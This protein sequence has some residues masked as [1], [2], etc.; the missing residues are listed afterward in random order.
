MKSNKRVKRQMRPGCLF[1]IVIIALGAIILFL[2]PLFNVNKITVEGNGRLSRETILNAS[3]IKVGQNIF[4]M[5]TSSAQKKIESLQYIEEAMVRRKFPNEISIVV[6]EGIVSAYIAH[7]KN[8]LGV[9]MKGETV[10]Y[11]SKGARES[12]APVVEGLTVTK[13]VMGEVVEVSEKDRFELMLRM[14]KTLDEKGILT[15][16]TQINLKN[17][18]DIILMYMDKLKIEFGDTERYER[19]F[20]EIEGMLE[21]KMDVG[22]INLYGERPTYKPTMD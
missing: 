5:S 22:K 14:M 12:G 2:T 6:K 3:E 10:C 13:K 7:E 17:K 4:R 11:I 9:N 16:M 18:N 1:S 19:K 21:K 15:S 8:L 20:D